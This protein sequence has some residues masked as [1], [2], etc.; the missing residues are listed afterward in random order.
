MKVG[1]ERRDLGLSSVPPGR[2]GPLGGLEGR[3]W[4]PW[5]G[6]LCGLA[7]LVEGRCGEWWLIEPSPGK[8]MRE[9]GKIWGRR[10]IVLLGERGI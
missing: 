9:E 10:K 7:A 8:D 4:C 5:L 2:P 3:A 6:G 1:E